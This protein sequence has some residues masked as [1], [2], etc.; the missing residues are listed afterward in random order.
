M[1]NAATLER[2]PMTMGYFRLFLR[3][4]GTTPARRAALLAGTGVT[5][6][7]LR[8]PSAEI[9]LFQQVKQIENITALCG[10]GWALDQSELWNPP[11]QGPV[12]IAVLAA[13]TFGASI[14]VLKRYAH[15]RAPYY[16]A[17]TTRTRRTMRLSLELAVPL[18]EDQWRPMVEITF[19]A[20][21]SLT[22]VVLGQMP[23]DMHFAFAGPAPSYA[24]KI[25]NSFG[26]HVTFGAAENSIT[27]PAS[28]LALQ[29]PFSDPALFQGVLAELRQ[30]VA[31]LENP[32]DLRARVERLLHT[33]PDGRL[34]ADSAARA[35][36]VSRRTLVR[37]LGQTD[38]RFRD[39]LDEEM[40]RRA[41][42]F[43]QLRTL[44]RADVAE[45][46]GYR[47]PTSF[48]RAC[49]RWFKGTRQ[50]K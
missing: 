38:T 10:E 24:R 1:A 2:L 26:K 23:D 32:I 19:M 34:D 21:K 18:R 44:S 48:R 25:H 22:A 27:F 40:K 15:V 47:D 20:L 39:L 36:G 13:P 49:R 12:G 35:I 50:A 29:P 42:K 33:M 16:R 11:A 9:S 41:A 8:S 5:E 37:R 17:H 46:L 6:R 14:D 7:D 4:Y 43:L 31:R 28:W 3:C 30:A 45:R